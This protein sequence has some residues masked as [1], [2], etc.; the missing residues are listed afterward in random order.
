MQ[1]KQLDQII[2]RTQLG[3]ISLRQCKKAYQLV[4]RREM[5]DRLAYIE[6]LALAINKAGDRKVVNIIRA[7]DRI[8]G[9]I[10]LVDGW[11]N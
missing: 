3:K 2:R 4:F 9:P 6:A 5:P 8:D 7:I 11:E 10:E 1:Q